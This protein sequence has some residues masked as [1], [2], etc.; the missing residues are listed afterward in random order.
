MI[1]HESNIAALAGGGKILH[2]TDR[3]T[4][5]AANVVAWV[6]REGLPPLSPDDIHAIHHMAVEFA[7][8]V[9]HASQ[10]AA[11]HPVIASVFDIAREGAQ[12]GEHVIICT[13]KPIPIICWKWGNGWREGVY[14]SRHVNVL[15][16]MVE[17]HLTV[18]HKFICITDNAKGCDC[19][20]MP[21]WGFPVVPTMPRKPNCYRR[22]RMFSDWAVDAIGPRF[23]W[24]DLDCVI[25]GNI[26]HLVRRTEDLVM[27]EGRAAT[28]NGSLVYHRTGTRKQLW[29]DFDPRT[30]PA[31]AASHRRE[32]GRPMIGSDQAW[33]SAK[34]PHEAKYTHERDGVSQFGSALRNG[35]VVPQHQSIVFYAGS[36]KPWDDAR[37]TQMGAR[38]LWQAWAEYD[39]HRQV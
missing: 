24:I 5:E 19:E 25:L 27:L 8:I 34:C 28:Y 4:A 1:D 31:W 16:R 29:D 21:L 33:I 9:L 36:I 38:K 30:S 39:M 3:K 18:P 35:S 15:K 37:L 11:L 10:V 6:H 20:T 23:M 12:D 32:N 17:K 26:D 14:E 2:F 13:P 22:L 7:Y